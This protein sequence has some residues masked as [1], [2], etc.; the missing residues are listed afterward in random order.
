M[1]IYILDTD[2]S[3]SNNSSGSRIDSR[4]SI[5]LSH[6]MK[7]FNEFEMQGMDVNLINL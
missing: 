1:L 7:L 2:G 5:H 3:I 4:D 6:S